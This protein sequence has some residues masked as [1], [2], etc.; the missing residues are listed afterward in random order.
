MKVL[1]YKDEFKSGWDDFLDKAKN[2][3]FLFKRN[4]LEYHKD[5]FTDFSLVVQDEKDKIIAVMPASLHGDT[6]ISHGGITYGGLVLTEEVKLNRYLI[7]FRAILQFLAEENITTLEYKALPVF[8][9]NLP[10]QEEEYVM[11]LLGAKTFRVDTS[12]TV[13]L[14]NPVPYQKRRLRS[15]KKAK[16][17]NFRIEKTS[18]FNSFWTEVLTPNLEAR[19]GRKPVHSV[20]EITYLASCFPNQI[21][22]VNILDG[23]QV[24]AGTTMFD[25]KTTAHAQYISANNFGR[26]SGALDMLFDYL[27]QEH[28]KHKQYFDFGI[29]NEQSGRYI[30]QGLLDWKEGFGGRTYVHKFYEI[31]P[32]KYVLLNEIIKE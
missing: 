10:A 5:R 22:Q 16:K 6:V 13:D 26:S 11:F 23:D 24:V 14:K 25:M 9:T 1:K 2:S 17:Q 4:F 32:Q 19:F 7:I 12:L 27:I 8:Y 29:C 15:V 18:D 21:Y 20:E 28:Y 3:T 31:D 30:N